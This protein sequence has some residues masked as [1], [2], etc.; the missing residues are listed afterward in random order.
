MRIHQISGSTGL[1]PDP[2]HRLGKL[3]EDE[4]DTLRMVCVNWT[5]LVL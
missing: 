1:D 2:Q 4:R 3:G 5:I